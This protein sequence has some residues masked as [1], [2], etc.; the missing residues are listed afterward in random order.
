MIGLP[1]DKGL[2]ENQWLRAALDLDLDVHTG[3]EVELLK[4]VHG[5]G[6][7]ID[8]V[9]ETL[10]S[11]HFELIGGFLVGV[12]GAV[13][14]ELLNACRQ[15]DRASYTGAGAFRGFDYFEH[16]FIECAKVEGAEANADTLILHEDGAG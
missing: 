2:N 10:V 1:D 13:H 7:R 14:G 5:A 3:R 8:D 16:T 6:G 11:A 4:L 12:H 9:E 15:R